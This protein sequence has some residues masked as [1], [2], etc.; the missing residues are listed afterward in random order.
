MQ[1]YLEIKTLQVKSEEIKIKE[2]KKFNSFN[3]FQRF[4]VMQL[5]N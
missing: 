4:S 5:G 1:F 2:N 3:S